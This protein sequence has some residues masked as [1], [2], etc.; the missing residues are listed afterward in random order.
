VEVRYLLLL[1]ALIRSG[2]TDASTLPLAMFIART[3]QHL[4][5]T[6]LLR[7]EQQEAV[8]AVDNRRAAAKRPPRRYAV[9]L[10][11]SADSSLTDLL[12]H[13]PPTSADYWLQASLLQVSLA[14]AATHSIFPSFRH[15]DLHA[16]NVLVQRIDTAALR[17]ALGPVLPPGYPLVVEYAFGGRRWQVDLER[18]PF[19]CLLWDLSFS[20]ICAEEAQRAGLDL[21]VPRHTTFGSVVHLS[22]TMP[23]QYLDLRTLVDTIRWVL[24]QGTVWQEG[25]KATTRAQLDSIVPTNVSWADKNMSNECKAERQLRVTHGSLQHTSPTT[26]LRWTDTF[27]AFRVDQIDPTLRVRPVYC[28][29]GSEFGNAPNSHFRWTSETNIP[30]IF[31]KLRE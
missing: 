17:A 11:E 29:Q 23:N 27:D 19:R 8:I 1:T 7:P 12:F 15:N 30:V 5:A 16:S 9:L 28:L 25:L 31:S 4:C 2:L 21:V 20:S 22:K 24:M 10:A 26:L 3:G 13:A 6:G 14:L 18:A